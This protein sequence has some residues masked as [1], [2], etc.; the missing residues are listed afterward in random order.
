MFSNVGNPETKLK[1]I[2]TLEAAPDGKSVGGLV[3][4]HTKKRK[5]PKGVV[6]ITD[7]SA[8]KMFSSMPEVGAGGLGLS[9]WDE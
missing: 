6:T 9:G 5:K 7:S 1:N 4:D 8:L 2:S 3:I